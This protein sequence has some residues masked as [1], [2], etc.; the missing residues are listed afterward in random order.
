MLATKVYGGW[1]TWPNDARLSALHIRPACEASLR[2]LQTDH[3]DLYQMHH[4]DRETPWEE[5][6]QAMELLVAAGQGASTSAARNFAGWHIAQANE[7]AAARGIPRPR[8][9]SRAST[10]CERG[11]SSSR[12]SRRAEAYGLGV[13]PWSPLGG[14]L[15]GGALAKA[16]EGRPRD[17]P[18]ASSARREAPRTQLEACEGLCAELG[19]EPADVALAWL[20]H[21]PAVTAPIIGPRTLEQLDGRA[22]RA[23]DHASTQ[24]ALDAARRDLPRARAV[25]RPRPTPGRAGPGGPADC[26]MIA[27]RT[28]EMTMAE[29]ET[30]G[31]T[32][33]SEPGATAVTARHGAGIDRSEEWAQLGPVT[34]CALESGPASSA[35]G[36]HHVALLSPDVERTIAFY[37]DLLGSR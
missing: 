34:S 23:R 10:T 4:V 19:E 21:Q 18:S 37:Q 17:R 5:I 16:T 29:D 12:C 22:A 8:V 28:T 13:I 6:W 3:I 27:K 31:T 15:L 26:A 9:A 2:R 32:Q 25:R 1:A 30:T 7:A 33:T 14:G 20:L 24:D 36:V 35:R 11:R